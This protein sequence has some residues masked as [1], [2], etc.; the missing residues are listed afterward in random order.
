MTTNQRTEI[1]SL[2]AHYA[3]YPGLATTVRECTDGTVH[4]VASYRVPLNDSDT[5]GTWP[6]SQSHWITAS[7][8]PAGG[9]TQRVTP[10]SGVTATPNVSPNRKATQ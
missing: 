4:F 9:A 5:E 1:E 3:A 6:E 7:N 2:T 10:P 8:C